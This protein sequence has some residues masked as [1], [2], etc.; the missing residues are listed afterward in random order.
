MKR[1]PSR[2]GTPALRRKQA[3]AIT[4]VLL[5]VAAGCGGA[6]PTEPDDGLSRDEVSALV[7]T[8]HLVHAFDLGFDDGADLWPC[9]SGGEAETALT[10][11]SSGSGLESRGTVQ[12]S[13]CVASEAVNAFRI[14]GRLSVAAQFQLDSF[15]RLTGSSTSV[16]GSLTWESAGRSGTCSVDLTAHSDGGGTAVSGTICKT[17]VALQ[18]T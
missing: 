4:L 15:G 14:T 7:R 9:P 16:D 6:A 1:C 2:H 17:T 3:G 12:Y 8:L 13:G 11:G 10:F 18:L 5:W